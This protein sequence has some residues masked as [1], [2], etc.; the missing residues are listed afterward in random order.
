MKEKKL[1]ATKIFKR[2]KIQIQQ[3]GKQ[4]TLM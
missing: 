4:G 3:N 1:M 2:L